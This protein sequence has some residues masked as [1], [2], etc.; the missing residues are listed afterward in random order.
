LLKT[1]RFEQMQIPLGV[2]ATDLCTGEQVAFRDSGDVF[3]PIQASCSYPGLFHPVRVNG[4]LLVDGAMSTEVPALLAR[5]LGANYVVSVHLAPQTGLQVPSNLA[6]VI[7][8]CFQ[9]MQTHSEYG[10]R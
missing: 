1:Y 2:V 5:Q 9:I 4:H 7:H 8:R 10:W 6:Q 3:L